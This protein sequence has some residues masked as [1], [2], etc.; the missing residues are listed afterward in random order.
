MSYS[1][2]PAMDID[3]LRKA[4]E[5]S[6]LQAETRGLQQNFDAGIL[7]MDAKRL[8]NEGS[9]LDLAAKTALQPLAIKGAQQQSRLADIASSNEILAQ[10]A[11]EAQAADPADAPDI[12]DRG[13]KA[14]AEQGITTADQYVGHYRSDLAER[15]GDV[16]GGQKASRGA[17]KDQPPQA[18]D[19]PAVNRAL[20]SMPPEKLK[21]A[22]ANLNRAIEGF[23]RVKDKETW[24][25]ELQQLRDGGIDPSSFLPSLDWNPLN[26]AAA[27]KVVKN[28]IPYRDA[29]GTRA[30]LIGAGAA[31]PEAAPQGTSSYIGTDKSSGKPIYF[32]SS[33][34][35][36]TVGAREIGAKPTAS[37]SVFQLKH[38]MAVENGMSES[39]ALAF[40]NGQKPVPQ[41]RLMAMAKDQANRE[42]SNLTFAG[43]QIPNPQQWIDKKTQDNFKLLTSAAA[44]G[45][46]GA[47]A[48]GRKAPPPPAAIPQRAVDALKSAGGKPVTFQNGLSYRWDAK[49]QKAVQVQ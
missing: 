9:K 23:N 4:A 31:P 5:M 47:G 46:G 44:P 30:A 17:D 40:A 16:Y 13:M 8:S 27:A 25:A 41:E 39:D 48:G 6:R 3:P 28:L 34:G 32:N 24:D 35:K 14:A 19:A 2:L 49:A 22:H 7:D 33:T 37:V 11:R 21:S 26:Y 1:G 12:W 43:E 42:Y 10:V 36:E 29:M 38:D 18:F 20:A 15:V 45:P